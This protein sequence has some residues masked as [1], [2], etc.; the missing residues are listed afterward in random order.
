MVT[1]WLAD[2]MRRRCLPAVGTASNS[3]NHDSMTT[4]TGAA[5]L[6]GLRYT[7][8]GKWVLVP[9]LVDAPVLMGEVKPVHLAAMRS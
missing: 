3:A 7:G 1:S 9:G 4:Q 2:P 6:Q 5:P 8:H